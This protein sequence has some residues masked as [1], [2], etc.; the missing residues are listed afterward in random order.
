MRRRCRQRQG[1]RRRARAGAHHGVGHTQLRPLVDQGGAEGGLYAHAAWPSMSRCGDRGHRWCC[2]TASPKRAGCG[3]ASASIWPNRSPWWPSICPV[4]EARTPSGPICPTTAH[5]VADA[6]RDAVGN[7]PCAVLGYSLGA[8]VALHV[9]AQGGLPVRRCRPDRRDREGSKTAALGP[10]GVGRT[11]LGPTS[12]RLRVTSWPS[13]T[14]G[15]AARCSSARRRGRPRRATAQQR[16][17]DWP[18]ACV[19]AA[20]GPRNHCGTRCALFRAPSWPWPGP[21]TRGSPRTPSAWRV[22]PRPV[23]RRLVPAGGHAVHLAQPDHAGRI[24]EHWLRAVDPSSA[25]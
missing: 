24:V 17:P 22:S 14:R 9:L 18:R 25:G 2:C 20:P 3:V 13:S 12:S 16:R 5:L 11:T 15:C 8:R 1:E 4:T 19:C 6:A 21:T 23:S 10:S 7:A